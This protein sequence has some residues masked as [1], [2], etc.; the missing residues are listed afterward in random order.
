[1]V[2]AELVG[3]VLAGVPQTQTYSKLKLQLMAYIFHSGLGTVTCSLPDPLL[4]PDHSPKAEQLLAEDDQVRV[5][6][7][8]TGASVTLAENSAAKVDDNASR[9]M[10]QSLCLILNIIDPYGYFSADGLLTIGNINRYFVII[11]LIGV[12]G[13]FVIGCCFKS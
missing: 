5:T 6:L 2:G 9:R 10:S 13:V 12:L 4:V 11:V 3:V 8:P 7:L 1:M